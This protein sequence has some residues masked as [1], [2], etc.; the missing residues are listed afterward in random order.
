MCTA[1]YIISIELF[2]GLGYR[3]SVVLWSQEVL[4]RML[5]FSAPEEVNPET[6][7]IIQL[8]AKLLLVLNQMIQ[9]K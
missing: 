2:I 4:G 3:K 7:V 8:K 5:L 6:C 1:K 9:G